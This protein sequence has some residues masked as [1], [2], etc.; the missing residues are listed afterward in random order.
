MIIQ[1]QILRRGLRLLLVLGLCSAPVQAV[2]AMAGD[3]ASF[4]AT[5]QDEAIEQLTDPDIDADERE[6]RFR[7]LFNKGFDVPAIGRFVVGR[8]WRGATQKERDDFIKVFE[9][10][11][12]QRFM[13]L[14]SE[15]SERRFEIGK[16]VEDSRAKD[17]VLVASEI[18]R[19]EGDPYKVNWRI[20]FKDEEFK[21]LDIVAEGVSMAITLRSE[22]GSLIKSSGGKVSSL[23]EALRKKLNS[24]AFA[25]ANSN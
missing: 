6:Q 14:L 7:H 11:V 25:N 24:G 19:G 22:Y 13:P 1:N 21:V 4:L 20:R 18:A 16:V 17:H 10:V 3:A 2:D 5:L 9:D 12:V 23:T 15:G 8:Y